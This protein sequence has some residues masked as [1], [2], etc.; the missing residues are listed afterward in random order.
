M[1]HSLGNMVVSSMIQDHGLSVSKYLMCNS[2]VPAEAYDAS[3]SL[4]VPQ[5]VHPEWE[6]YPTNTWT[7]SYHSLFDEIP[8]D[9]RRLL[10]WPGRF[11]DV[12][13]YAVNFYST[14]DEVLELYENNNL[15]I[16]TGVMPG[17]I[18]N[19]DFGH[20]SWHKQE[21]FKGRAVL[22]TEH[23]GATQW[24]GWGFNMRLIPTA[25]FPVSTRKYTV[26]QAADMSPVQLR[27]D[28]VFNPYPVSIT[29]GVIPLLA[30]AAHLTQ[31]VPALTPPTGVCR[32]G[33]VFGGARSYNLN[34]GVEEDEEVEENGILKPNNWPTRNGYG[35]RWLHSDM[36]D[37]AF[38]FNYKLYEKFIDVGGLR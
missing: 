27:A 21:L 36:K 37:A 33:A 24:S 14:G 18:L 4:R 22:D 13:R 6:D 26:E 15:T 1:A 8:T 30:R 5:L 35:A 20:L 7:A 28:P 38:W 12:A 34:L 3:L 32:I 23:W 29:N 16:E 19:P 10:G 2:A 25:T 9:D 31:G 17:G 11:A